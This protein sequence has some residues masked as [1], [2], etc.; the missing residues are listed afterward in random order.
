M[1]LIVSNQLPIRFCIDDGPAAY[2]FNRAD[3]KKSKGEK[4]Q[5]NQRLKHLSMIIK[6]E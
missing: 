2:R 5:D 6:G 4:S 1:Q 3:D